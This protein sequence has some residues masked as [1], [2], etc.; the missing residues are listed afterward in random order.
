MIHYSEIW[1][2]PVEATERLLKRCRTTIAVEQNYTGQLANVIRAQ[3]G[4]KVDRRI[5]KYDG[6]QISPDEIV[7]SVRIGV[8]LNA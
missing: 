4:H 8:A 6:R 3:T 1:P 2:F 5:N 7:S